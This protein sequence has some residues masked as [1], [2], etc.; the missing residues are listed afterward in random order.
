MTAAAALSILIPLS[1][2]Q[3]GAEQAPNTAADEAVYRQQLDE[4]ERDLDRGLI[5]ETAADAA[6]TE[7]ARRLLAANERRTAGQAGAKGSPMGVRAG[8]ILAIAGLPVF[9][10]GLYMVLGSP[11]L[12]DQPLAARLTAPPE[13]QS[14][15]ELVARVERHLAQNPED[16]Q[17]WAVIAPVLMRMGDAQ[18]AARA[19]SNAV[20]LLG[21]SPELVTDMGEAMTMANEGMISAGARAAFE[22][23]VELDP[24]AVKPRFFLALAL[25]QEGKTDEAILAWQSL[26]EGADPEAVWV[27]AAMDELYKLG[28]EA[29]EMASQLRG[30]DRGPD[31]SDVEAAAEMAPEDRTAMITG[32]VQGLADRLESEGGSADEWIQLMRAYMVMGDGTKAQETYEAAT[33]A[34]MGNPADLAKINAA[35]RELGLGGT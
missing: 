32:M 5:D 28:G 23:A 30:P 33:E 15:E 16:G 17:G 34:F 8:K 35:A 7:I 4:V 11:E 31:R 6:R 14:V 21:P 2:R 29:P 3:G 27:P 22:Q 13:G 25:G 9:T 24:A 19:Y 20:R 1:R 18:G 26:L 12:P 10:L